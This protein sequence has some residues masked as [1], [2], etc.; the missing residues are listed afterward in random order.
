MTSAFPLSRH[1][2]VA[3]TGR[4]VEKRNKSLDRSKNVRACRYAA[5][6]ACIGC[7]ISVIQSRVVVGYSNGLVSESMPRRSYLLFF[8][9]LSSACSRCDAEKSAPT[10][11][12]AVESAAPV[13]SA[14]S[15]A[16][17]GDDV[18]PV[19]PK[20][21]GPPDPLAEKLCGALHEFPVKRRAECCSSS[22]GFSLTNECIRMLSHALRDKSITI[23]SA[24]VDACA[25][26]MQTAHEGCEWV[27]PTN[28]SLPAA[29]DG[30]LQGNVAEGKRCRS[31]LE[32]ADGLRC[33][34]LG[35]TDSGVCRKPLPSGY[36]CS[37]A[38]DPLAAV[39]RQDAM[40]SKHPECS[41][42]CAQRRCRDA[43]ALH[44]ACKTHVEC[45]RGQVC[46]GGSCEAG[47]LPGE[48]KPCAQG[49]CASGLRCEKDTC[50]ARKNAGASCTSDIECR[51]GCVRG[52]AGKEGTCGPKCTLR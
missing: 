9:L 31:S 45:G 23:E 6:S 32:C 18:E 27:G 15:T 17:R 11:P 50:V 25:S 3:T 5:Q 4:I 42:I 10:A 51:G 2:D 24:A 12:S 39:T 21:A 22:P 20:I 29:C 7:T 30:I 14:E 38:V 35:P 40:E 49:A 47:A 8:L 41:G 44:G 13:P 34:G 1:P 26:A 16:I 28:V 43:V 52:D 19:Y 46:L 33:L 36:P 37:L 48:G